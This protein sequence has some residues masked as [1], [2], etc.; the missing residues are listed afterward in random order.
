MP[1][2]MGMEAARKWAKSELRPVEAA[3]KWGCAAAMAS[4]LRWAS[5]DGGIMAL[6]ASNVLFICCSGW[7]DAADASSAPTM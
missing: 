5:V 3:P 6:G 1:G 7:A 4:E 2:L